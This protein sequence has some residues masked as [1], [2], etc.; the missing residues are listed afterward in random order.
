MKSTLWWLGLIFGTLSVVMLIKHGFDYGFV[1]PLQLVLDFY[2]QA[3]QLLFGWAEPWLREQLVGLRAWF[4]L[5]LSLYGHWKHVFLLMMLYFNANAR[6]LWRPGDK[7][8]AIFLFAVGVI[9]ALGVA[10][11]V[12]VVSLRDPLSPP[13]LI[14]VPIL[15]VVIHELAMALWEATFRERP[16]G[17][18]W[19]ARLRIDHRLVRWAI[20]LG[21]GAFV[22]S[23]SDYGRALI[24]QFPGVGLLVLALFIVLFAIDH[25]YESIRRAI[26]YPDEGEKW[27]E[28][29]HQYTLARIGLLMLASILGALV[30]IATNAG[31]KLAGL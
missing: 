21:T 8:L 5:D 3:M 24:K 16:P 2:E 29:F 27:W 19:W 6:I 25:I 9:I 12:S 26:D 15:G 23:I 1:A 28:T 17:M 22:V 14:S 7:L 18:S 20:V 13:L 31:L 4:G 10:I 11:G 30:F